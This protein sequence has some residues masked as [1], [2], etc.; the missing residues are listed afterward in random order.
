MT[1]ERTTDPVQVMLAALHAA[2]RGPA[3]PVAAMTARIERLG[4]LS[5]EE[6]EAALTLI[7]QAVAAARSAREAGGGA[8]E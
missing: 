1:D 4:A 5:R 7:E 6:Q 2:A 3:D 8:G